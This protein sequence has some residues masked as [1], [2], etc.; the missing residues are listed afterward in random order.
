M[1]SRVQ[2]RLCQYQLPKGGINV[3]FKGRKGWEWEWGICMFG[4]TSGP[5]IAGL[6]NE[7]ILGEGY[8]YT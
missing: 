2:L 1:A 6:T 4:G 5:W 8:M 3:W 7:D